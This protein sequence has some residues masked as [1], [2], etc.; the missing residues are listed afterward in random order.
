LRLRLKELKV[1]FA[2]N[3]FVYKKKE[4][5]TKLDCYTCQIM[6]CNFVTKESQTM[7]RH[8]RTIHLKDKN[9]T[10]S[11][12]YTTDCSHEANFKTFSGL[13]Y[14]LREFHPLFFP[15]SGNVTEVDSNGT[16]SEQGSTGC[17]STEITLTRQTNVVI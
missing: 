16:Y 12:L 3:A 2:K 15:D 8:L 10:S 13:K 6:Q 1:Q 5:K 4:V 9:F 7:L 14:H 17:V 11:C